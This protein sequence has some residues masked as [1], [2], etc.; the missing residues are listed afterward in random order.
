MPKPGRAFS[1]AAT[2]EAGMVAR[3]GCNLDGYRRARTALGETIKARF[4]AEIPVRLAAGETPLDIKTWCDDVIAT[5]EAALDARFRV[6]AFCG[7]PWE[8]KT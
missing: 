3:Y 6:D 7:A 1:Q 2:L 4:E 8:G 5:E